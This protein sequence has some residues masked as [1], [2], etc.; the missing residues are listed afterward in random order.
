[1]CKGFQAQGRNRL[2]CISNGIPAGFLDY[3]NSEVCFLMVH[4]KLQR[5]GIG[6]RLLNYFE[7]RTDSPQRLLCFTNNHAALRFYAAHGYEKLRLVRGRFFG[8]SRINYEM[9]KPLRS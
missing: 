7:S 1:M 5:S 3:R 8:E 4:S 6:S 9:I 2:I